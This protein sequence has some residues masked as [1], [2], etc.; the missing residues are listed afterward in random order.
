MKK[1]GTYRRQGG[2][3]GETGKASLCLGAEGQGP[4]KVGSLPPVRL[5][6]E[7]EGGP[8]GRGGLQPL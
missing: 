7:C 8:E 6:A 4:D 5:G 2:G 1:V 3:G